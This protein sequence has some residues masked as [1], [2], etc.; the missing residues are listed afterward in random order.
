MLSR[1]RLVDGSGREDNNKKKYKNSTRRQEL[2]LPGDSTYKMPKTGVEP[3]WF[4]Q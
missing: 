4:I 1:P 3:K 2:E